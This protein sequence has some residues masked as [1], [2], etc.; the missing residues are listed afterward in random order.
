MAI[1]TTVSE[2]SSITLLREDECENC[3]GTFDKYNCCDSCSEGHDDCEINEC[4]DC[5]E[6][7]MDK[8][9]N[10]MDADRDREMML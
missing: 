6:R 4:F 10:L 2:L 1:T 8:A 7:A 3:G 5:L 9:E